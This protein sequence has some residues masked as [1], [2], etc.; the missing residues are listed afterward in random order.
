MDGNYNE[1]RSLILAEWKKTR[2]KNRSILRR[3]EHLTDQ[4]VKLA[5]KHEGKIDAGTRDLIYKFF[6]LVSKVAIDQM[7]ADMLLLNLIN[8]D[9]MSS[10]N[11]EIK[12]TREIID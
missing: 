12:I 11:N 1:I 7:K 5:E 6:G 10:G 4:Q 3:M 8:E 9:G 2:E